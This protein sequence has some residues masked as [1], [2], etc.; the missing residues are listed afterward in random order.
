M[1]INDLLPEDSDSSDEDYIPGAKPEDQVSEVESDGD[2][3][4]P[5]SD[6]EDGSKTNGKKGKKRRKQTNKGRKRSRA[7]E[8]PAE[9]G[10][11]FKEIQ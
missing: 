5:L 2:P 7:V 1:N 8:E 6:A 3:E 4:D 10:K 11:L 9:E